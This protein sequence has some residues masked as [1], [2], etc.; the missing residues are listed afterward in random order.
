M[1]RVLSYLGQP[2]LLNE[3]LY[4]PDNSLI[5]QSYNP[6][7][8]SYML[9][10]AGFGIVAWQ[11]DSIQPK[12]PFLY[13]SQ[14]LPFYDQNLKNLSLK[15]TPKCL[16]AHVRGVEDMEKGIISNQN[17]HPF[18][19]ENTSI[20]FAHNGN[21]IGFNDMSFD[22]LKYT[23]SEFKKK[24]SVQ[25]IVKRSTHCFYRNFTILTLLR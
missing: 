17:I 6:K 13:H 10:L 11:Q 20:A 18:L 2:I 23:R 12:R 21:L 16:I 3:L 22:M 5:T 9:N 19:F 4:N 14:E 24:S 25:P 15:I 1:C 7:L 8:M